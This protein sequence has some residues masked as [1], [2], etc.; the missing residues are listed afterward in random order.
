MSVEA[1]KKLCLN[2]K[3]IAECLKKPKLTQNLELVIEAAKVHDTDKTTG[4]LLLTL[5]QAAT[6]DTG[7]DDQKTS[8]IARAI[9]DGRLL[10][11]QQLD[12]S[13]PRLE[14]ALWLTT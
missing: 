11:T 7:L 6:K 8:Y 12:G 5:A 4:A 9:G 13:S 3:Q 10:S 1:F 2:D 14:L